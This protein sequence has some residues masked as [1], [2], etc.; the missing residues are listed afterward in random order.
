MAFPDSDRH[1]SVEMI[2]AVPFCLCYYY[3]PFFLLYYKNVLEKY[4]EKSLPCRAASWGVAPCLACRLGRRRAAGVS[5]RCV[6]ALGNSRRRAAGVSSR[7]SL[8]F[9]PLCTRTEHLLLAVFTLLTGAPARSVSALRAECLRSQFAPVAPLRSA[10]HSNRTFITRGLYFIDSCCT[11][12]QADG[13]SVY[14]KFRSRVTKLSYECRV[15]GAN[16]YA[17]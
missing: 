16:D 12:A 4:T 2:F 7:G 13:R 1:R 8:R 15:S 17:N 9:A 3:S 6:P 10:L 5:S 11:P 14:N